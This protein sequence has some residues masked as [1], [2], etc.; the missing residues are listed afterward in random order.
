[1]SAEF[2]P[3]VALALDDFVPV[4][5]AGVAVALLAKH[6]AATRIPGV[7]WRAWVGAGAIAVGG[8]CKAVWKLIVALGGPDLVWLEKA[9][10]S[11]L[12]PGFVTLGFAM[13]CVWKG[14]A[15][16]H[17]IGGAPIAVGFTAGTLLRADWPLLVVTIVAATGVSVLGLLLARR[18]GDQLAAGLFAFQIVLAFGLAPLAAP[19]QTSS[20]QWLEQSLNTVAQLALLMAAARLS[21]RAAVAPAPAVLVPL[22]ATT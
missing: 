5:L 1:M 4:V 14:R 21:R 7:P 13:L 17:W 3:S 20:K 22:E 2:V 18:Q 12:M 15:L 16:A 6:A 11:F 9:L 19:P 8:L 10:F